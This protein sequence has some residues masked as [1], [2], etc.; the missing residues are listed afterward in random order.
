MVSCRRI[1]TTPKT[2]YIAVRHWADLYPFIIG[3]GKSGGFYWKSEFCHDTSP[4][5]HTPLLAF[6]LTATQ[7]L[8]PT[9]VLAIAETVCE[10]E[11]Y[12]QGAWTLECSGL[13][14]LLLE[15]QQLKLSETELPAIAQRLS[16][17]GDRSSR[18]RRVLRKCLSRKA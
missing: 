8:T 16:A 11:W 14:G 18:S 7:Q 2:Y 6:L 4:C 5:A 12:R 15:L 1:L 9:T 10:C 3:D 13:L 17:L